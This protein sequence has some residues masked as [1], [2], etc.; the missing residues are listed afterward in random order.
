MDYKSPGQNRDNRERRVFD[1]SR[2]PHAASLR[3]QYEDAIAAE[4]WDDRN[5][6]TI[7]F[8]TFPGALDILAQLDSRKVQDPH[9]ELLSA[10]AT[11][12][13]EDAVLT[14]SVYIPESQESWFLRKLDDYVDTVKDERP[15]H[16]NL[17]ESI[18]QIR[19]A[20]ARL[21]WTDP[22]ECFPDDG[23]PVW[24]EVW[25]RK[26]SDIE[27]IELEHLLRVVRLQGLSCPPEQSLKFGDRTVCLLQG[28]VKVS[29]K[30]SSVST[31]LQ[32]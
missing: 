30:S 21:L 25:L 26:N 18:E 2:R 22:P 23:A 6:R 15:R 17:I 20:T 3:R 4:Q 27:D 13:K 19:K 5:S 1:G 9:I 12:D 31:V 11:G 7:T 14:A 24:W 10:T 28:T 32:S 16:R 8:T 29:C